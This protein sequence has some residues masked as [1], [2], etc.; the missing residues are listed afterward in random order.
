M[1]LK[2]SDKSMALGKLLLASCLVLGMAAGLAAAAEEKYVCTGAEMLQYANLVFCLPED[3]VVEPESIDEANYTGGKEVS[4]SMLLDGKRVGLHIIY[5]CLAPNRELNHEELKGVLEA[6]D[7]IMAEANYN[8]TFPFVWGLLGNQ[9]IVAYQP[10]NETVALVLMD[11]NMSET[12]MTNFLGNMSINLT[13]GATPLTPGSC[14]DIT[15]PEAAEG[16]AAQS[17][18]ASQETAPAAVAQSTEEKPATGQEKMT[19]DIDAAKA[20]IEQLKKSI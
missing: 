3:V 14:P 15:V 20:Q 19:T 5:P 7:P 9:V 8:D 4:A 12:M 6:Y 1:K 10:S 18:A 2:S 11:T 13:E 16:S 17:A